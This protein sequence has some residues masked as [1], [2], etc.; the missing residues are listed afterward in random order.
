MKYSQSII[1]KQYAKAYLR[2]YGSDLKLDDLANMKSAVG[3]FRRHHNFMSLVSLLCTTSMQLEFTIIEELFQHFLL[4]L[5]LKKLIPLLIDH[6]RLV[7]FAQV[8]QDICCLYFVSHNLQ[9]LTIFTATP[10][11]D[12]ATEQFENFFI[13]LSGKQIISSVVLDR[14][15]IAGVRMQSDFFFWEYS[16]AAR[17]RTLRQKLLIEG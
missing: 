2:E 10:L 15:L 9:E 14:S 13:K 3:F 7:L 8:L 16:I 11:D 12:Q 1:A 6:K 4:P 5:S 17:L